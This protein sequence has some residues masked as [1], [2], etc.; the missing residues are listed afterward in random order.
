ERNIRPSKR[1]TAHN[2]C[3][4]PF[5]I[6]IHHRKQHQDQSQIARP[7]HDH[8]ASVASELRIA[9]INTE[10][11]AW[12]LTRPVWA[13]IPPGC[14]RNDPICLSPHLYRAQNLV[15]RLRP[16]LL[17]ATILCRSA[18]GKSA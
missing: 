11:G 5:A 17:Y 1:L 12:V 9:S 4:A 10:F 13:N 3:V 14:K 15:E 16:Q 6:A 2:R 8:D 18:K 7:L